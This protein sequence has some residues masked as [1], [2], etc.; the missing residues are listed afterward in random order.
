M[1][2]EK[3]RTP[4]LRNPFANFDAVSNI[5]PCPQKELTFEIWT[6]SILSDA[7]DFS[8]PR[9]IAA[10]T[11]SQ[12]NSVY[13]A[14]IVCVLSVLQMTVLF[15]ILYDT[16]STFSFLAEAISC[17]GFATKL[18]HN[19]VDCWQLAEDR[20]EWGGSQFAVNAHWTSRRL[21]VV[22]REKFTFH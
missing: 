22:Q 16:V 1:G 8:F 17:T 19:K 6:E 20:K 15:I 4:P 14:D 12:S 11:A 10:V 9:T 18:S 7:Q 5:S 2:E 3:I 21:H 13:C